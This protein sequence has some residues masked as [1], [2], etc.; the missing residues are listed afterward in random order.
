MSLPQR[1]F[2]TSPEKGWDAFTGVGKILRQPSIEVRRC[3]DTLEARWLNPLALGCCVSVCSVA[4]DR[5]RSL[6]ITT[7]VL[8]YSG[9][10]VPSITFTFFSTVTCSALIQRSLDSTFVSTSKL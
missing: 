2:V 8:G 6:S 10:S 1:C 5:M 3:S 4:I 9:A 7:V